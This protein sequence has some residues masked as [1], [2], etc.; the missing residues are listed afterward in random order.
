[1]IEASGDRLAEFR[2]SGDSPTVIRP[3]SPSIE[4]AG[5]EGARAM[6]QATAAQGVE[7]GGEGL[8][9]PPCPQGPYWLHAIALRS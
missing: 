3:P 6:A 4:G 1:M 7:E 9:L 8:R 2:P 5:E